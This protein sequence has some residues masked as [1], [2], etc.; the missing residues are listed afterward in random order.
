MTPA[1]IDRR[2]VSSSR[3]IVLSY[4]AYLVF[5]GN[6]WFFCRL[7]C[8]DYLTSNLTFGFCSIVLSRA[9]IAQFFTRRVLHQ[10]LAEA[11]VHSVA[12]RYAHRKPCGSGGQNKKSHT[13][14]FVFPAIHS[15][16]GRSQEVKALHCKCCY[17]RFKSDRPLHF[18]FCQGKRCAEYFQQNH[19]IRTSIH[20]WDL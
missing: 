19:R 8:H 12:K 3:E 13:C 18:I 14:L 4:S 2:V 5:S 1:S 20:R 15:K 16:W 17:R 6:L 7:I 10:N 11:Q 9:S